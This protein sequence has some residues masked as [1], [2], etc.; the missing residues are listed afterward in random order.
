M[1]DTTKKP[2]DSASGS[3]KPAVR[4][5]V[6]IEG[7]WAVRSDGRTRAS[8]I[9]ESKAEAVRAAREAVQAGGGQVRIHS[10][11]GRI[12]ESITIGRDPFAKI[13]AVEG[14][15]PTKEA[16][17]RAIEFEKKDLSSEQRRHAIIKA[18]SDRS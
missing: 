8:A 7:G 5:V 17:K 6:P 14:I 1:S 18:F 10:R 16:R 3:F 15:K 4:Y 2:R 13:S 9:F 12:R 11:E